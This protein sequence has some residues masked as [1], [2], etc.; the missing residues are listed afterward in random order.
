MFRGLR[1]RLTLLYLLASLA[2]IALISAGSYG[3][4]DQYFQSTTSLALKHR[5]AQEFQLLGQQLP[6]DLADAE[7]IWYSTRPKSIPTARPAPG[8]QGEDDHEEEHEAPVSGAS[9]DFNDVEL[10][11]TFALP[12]SAEGLVVA[13]PGV[14]TPRIAPDRESAAAALQQ[15]RDWRTVTVGGQRVRLLTY[16]LTGSSGPALVQVGRTL[17]DQDR[18]LQRLLLGLLAL[19]GVSAVAL[20]M[21]SWWLSG[22]SLRPAQE[23]WERQQSFVANASHELRAP[24]TLL[25]A[26]TEVALRSMP[27]QDQDRRALLTDVLDEADHMGRLVEDLLLLSRLD[28]GQL[29]IV[30]QAIDLPE[31]LSDVARQVGRV[32][33]ERGV[34]LR[35]EGARGVAL[36]D[37]TRLRQV[38]IILLDNALRHTPAGGT[39]AIA[40]RHHGRQVELSVADTGSGIAP[41]HLPHVFERFYRGG[42]ARGNDGSGSGLGLSIARALVEAQ[43]GQIAVESQVG[44]GTRVAVTLPAAEPRTKEAANYANAR[45]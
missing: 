36:A 26:S 2:L 39:I 29:K 38:L 33:E 20:G 42:S 15:G 21:C 10:A 30:H 24:L 34:R 19:G 16:R 4:L 3:L 14:G 35:T 12:L 25:R 32:A 13:Q 22:R 37:A 28:A 31:L 45:E 23:A 27:H 40:T 17:A 8:T 43:G 44:Q 9:E 6:A 18:V 1:L 11:A 5:M 41:E 7:R